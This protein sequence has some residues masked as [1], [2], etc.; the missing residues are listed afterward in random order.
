[1]GTNTSKTK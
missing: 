1:M